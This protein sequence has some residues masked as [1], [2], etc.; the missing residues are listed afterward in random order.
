MVRG[1]SIGVVVS[2]LIVSSGSRVVAGPAPIHRGADVRFTM[3]GTTKES[4]LTAEGLGVRVSKRV[5]PETVKIRIEVANDAIEVDATVGGAVRLARRGKSVSLNMAVRDTKAIATVRRLTDG[6]AALKSFGAMIAALESDERNAT[7]SMLTSWALVNA[8][9]GDE[10]IAIG[11]ARKLAAPPAMS[12]TP[13]SFTAREETPIVCWAEYASTITQYY[14]EY[15]Q[16]L[17]DYAWIPGMAAVC[18][19]E[20]LVK[21][22]LAWFWVI[23]CSGGVPV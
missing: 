3:G 16:C 6:S 5:G 8:I 10:Q 9:R 23:G 4:T 2:M 19:F 14:F 15:S 13:A 21:A 22:E 12:M 17:I 7:K 1:L 11:V 18:S 20:W